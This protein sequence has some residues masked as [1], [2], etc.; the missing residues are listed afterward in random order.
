MRLPHEPVVH[1]VRY[2]SLPHRAAQVA[3]VAPRL[4][5]RLQS[6]DL[7]ISIGDGPPRIVQLPVFSHA[8]G[9]RRPRDRVD[10]RRRRVPCVAQRRLARGGPA[11]RVVLLL[12]V[13]VQEQGRREEQRAH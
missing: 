6:H 9:R 12:H 7:P 4:E 11:Q 2:D 10:E 8:L 3:P 5:R 1:G 13:V